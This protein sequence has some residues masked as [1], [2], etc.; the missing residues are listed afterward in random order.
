MNNPYGL[1]K[2]IF[3]RQSTCSRI[4]TMSKFSG[5][6]CLY[7]PGPGWELVEIGFETGDEY[8]LRMFR[9]RSK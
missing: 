9:E 4:Q 7:N 3:I 1:W 2:V 5:Y 6:E 8:E